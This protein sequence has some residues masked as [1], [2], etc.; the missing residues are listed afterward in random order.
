MLCQSSCCCSQF[1]KPRTNN[2]NK[3]NF[4][5]LNSYKQSK[6]LSA[7]NI[8]N[9]SPKKEGKLRLRSKSP[10]RA[11]FQ[12]LKINKNNKNSAEVK[13]KITS[14]KALTGDIKLVT[15]KIV[16]GTFA[17][18][19]G[20][21]TGVYDG[22]D[23]RS[24]HNAR[25]SSLAPIPSPL[26]QVPFLMLVLLLART[27]TQEIYATFCIPKPRLGILSNWTKL[28]LVQSQSLPEWS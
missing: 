10:V 15:L 16:K 22:R 19:A 21:F 14:I 20:Q 4:T 27:T 26:P 25:L 8:A 17:F 28:A 2:Y 7:M 13:A 5:F 6:M 9:M 11:V 1:S 23:Q 18:Q 24:I 3:T 12:K